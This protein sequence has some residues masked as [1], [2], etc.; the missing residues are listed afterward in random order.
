MADQT[1]SPSFSGSNLSSS[2]T[3]SQSGSTPPPPAWVNE[4]PPI[5]NQPSIAQGNQP[6]PATQSSKS[7]LDHTAANNS[8]APSVPQSQVQKSSNVD[9]TS[10]FSGSSPQSASMS[11][12]NSAFLSNRGNPFSAPTEVGQAG[13][14]TPTSS[15]APSS[16]S[17]SK[18]G[19]TPPP[20]PPPPP[21]FSSSSSAKNNK[22][23]PEGDM[24]INLRSKGGAGKKAL[25]GVLGIGVVVGIVLMV[26]QVV[27]PRLQSDD[28]TPS[29]P[30]GQTGIGESKTE[31]T[32]TYWGLWEPSNVMEEIF[33]S[34][35]QDNPH[36]KI[37]YV[38]QSIK[39]YRERLQSTLA[40]GQ[41]PDIFRYHNTWLPMLKN[42]LQ[43]DTS[44]SINLS[45]YFPVVKKDVSLGGETFGVPIGFDSLAL[46]YNRNMLLKAG[47]S[48]PTTWDELLSTAKKLTVY[49]DQNRIQI[50][51]AAL[52]T[53]NNI[54]HFSDILGLMLL[55]NGAD[56]GNPSDK[57]AEDTLRF[58]TLFT[59]REKVWDE[60]LPPSTYAFAT[61]KV[62]M[63][64]APSWRIF[65][66]KEMNPTLEFATTSVPQLPG[67]KIAWAT[68]WVEGVSR[69]SKNATEAWKLLG[70]MSQDE[71]LTK[72][73]TTQSNSRLFGELYPK[74][75][76]ALSV[77]DDPLIGAFV[78]QGE[79]AKSWFLASR[80]FD[81]G[82]NDQTIK[83]YEDAVNSI[84]N[85]SQPGQILTTLT[86]GVKQVLT[87]YSVSTSPSSG[88][89]N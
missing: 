13:T 33:N 74:Q 35:Q 9:S 69:R 46:F 24:A 11:L 18:T 34:Y 39:D 89:A 47:E 23:S 72:L 88:I 19:Q 66:I 10:S 48:A 5:I 29:T 32:L 85:G 83:Y 57:M 27:L 51:G 58:Y 80:T 78:S 22:P 8:T 38:Q 53:T 4:S 60:T 40:S 15:E 86:K 20:P 31:V 76:L 54:D 65:E 42:E 25:F 14:N 12:D 52:G 62:A 28:S 79:Y 41:G 75:S 45:Q 64:F 44:N 3:A 6:T 16:P 77:K 2:K 59:T 21:A 68:Y 63:I 67:E 17:S 36:I 56:P 26:T 43:P 50:A 81:N 61:E 49:D 71:N 55:Q 37:N 82:L 70:Y 7:G 84:L 87:K 73:Y 1:K 30:K